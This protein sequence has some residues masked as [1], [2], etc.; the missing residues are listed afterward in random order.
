MSFNRFENE[1]MT[2]DRPQG[3]SGRRTEEWLTARNGTAPDRKPDQAQFG[4]DAD[5][6]AARWPF[7]RPPPS[8]SRHA[9]R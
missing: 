9:S 5:T 4:G 8:T 6:G 3:R 1:R 7:G 2:G